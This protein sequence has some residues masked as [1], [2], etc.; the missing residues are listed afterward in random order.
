[1]RPSSVS[2]DAEGENVG[3]FDEEKEI[4]DAIVAPIFDE[5]PLQ[6]ERLA[7]RNEAKTPDL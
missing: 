5:C 1:M 7:V 4:A 3:M 2:A 6:F